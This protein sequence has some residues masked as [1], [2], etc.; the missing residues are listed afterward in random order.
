M[1]NIC[2]LKTIQ[3]WDQMKCSTTSYL[4]LDPLFDFSELQFS[5]LQVDVSDNVAIHKISF[6]PFFQP[7][8]YAGSRDWCLGSHKCY[9][10]PGCQ[11]PFSSYTFSYHLRYYMYHY[12]LGNKPPQTQWH[13]KTSVISVPHS[14]VHGQISLSRSDGLEWYYDKQTPVSICWFSLENCISGF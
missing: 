12:L 1:R 10:I 9:F 13:F 3:I 8:R 14:G 11:L 2:K 4:I 6:L 7:W 5:I